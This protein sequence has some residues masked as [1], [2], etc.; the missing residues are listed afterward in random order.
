MAKYIRLTFKGTP[1]M[2]KAL[3]EVAEMYPDKVRGALY[4]V[5]TA[6]ILKPVQDVRIP[7]ATGNASR[8]GHVV[9]YKNK[10]RADV[11]FGGPVGSGGNNTEDA[12][13]V[14]PLHENLDAKHPHGEAKFLENQMNEESGTFRQDLVDEC[15]FKGSVTWDKEKSRISLGFAPDADWR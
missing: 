4:R 7:V 1:E 11:V 15:E 2:A 5:V 10:L 14:V 3:G 8:S 9:M 6:K 13:Y 12:N